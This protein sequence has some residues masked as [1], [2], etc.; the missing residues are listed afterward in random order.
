M[1]AKH[2]R[3]DI[4]KRLSDL[5]NSDGLLVARASTSAMDYAAANNH[6]EVLQWLHANRS[7]GMSAVALE[8]AAA[9][10]RL[11]V[12]QWIVEN[13]SETISKTVIGGAA[14]G[15]H[16]E[17]VKYLVEECG[18]QVTKETVSFA[19]KSGNVELVEYLLARHKGFD[20]VLSAEAFILGHVA[21]VDLLDRHSMSCWPVTHGAY[22]LSELISRGN[23]EMIKRLL[24]HYQA[25]NIEPRMS[26]LEMAAKYN[27]FDI[28]QY[29]QERIP[30]AAIS[31]QCSFY[32]ACYGGY[33]KIIHF[34]HDHYPSCP[35]SLNG[36]AA[37][38]HLDLVVWINTTV[39]SVVCTSAAID[40]AA[41]GGYLEIVKYLNENRSEGCTIAALS[42]AARLGRLDLVQYLDRNRPEISSNRR[43][44]SE[45]VTFAA[46]NGHIQVVEYM[47]RRGY[48]V[49]MAALDLASGNNHM[50][51]VKFIY[52]KQFASIPGLVFNVDH[53]ACNGH[54]EMVQWLINLKQDFSISE[55]ALVNVVKNGDIPM[56]EIVGKYCTLGNWKEALKVAQNLG[57]LD[58]I[59]YCE[60][61]WV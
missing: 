53:A 4:V 16:I 15:G 35:L 61:K 49:T 43:H 26:Y 25:N 14:Q 31:D 18:V 46:K 36:A 27:H 10:N 59:S 7:E 41:H 44:I 39:S 42:S 57:Y 58:I 56:L 8:S 33:S 24:S 17:I 21:V 38:G 34:I 51:V 32:N 1:A 2:G 48:R 5:R 19:A 11:D 9:N 6:L 30:P 52:E 60:K 22:T 13:R 3:L 45:P 54:K 28:L 23:L 40:S 20:H 50:E 55:K 29:L 37:G 47:F 12:V